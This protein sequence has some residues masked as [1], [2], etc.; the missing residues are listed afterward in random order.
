MDEM[1][2]VN[3]KIIQDKFGFPSVE[4]VRM[5]AKRYGIKSYRMGG[6]I[7]HNLRDFEQMVVVN[8]DGGIHENK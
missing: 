6:R 8:H 2:L 7:L 3:R 5:F 1:S 4:A